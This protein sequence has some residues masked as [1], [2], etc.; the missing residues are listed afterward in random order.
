VITQ[1]TFA[2]V[3]QILEKVN[4]IIDKFSGR[5][6]SVQI[7]YD[8]SGE[9]MVHSQFDNSITTISGTDVIIFSY[10]TVSPGSYGISVSS[11]GR[12]GSRIN[13]LTLLVKSMAPEDVLPITTDC[14]TNVG[15]RDV[16]LTGNN[17]DKLVI[18]GRAMQGLSPVLAAN[19]T[20]SITSDGQP[21]SLVSLKD[22]GVSPDSVRNDGIYSAYF[23][24]FQPNQGESR[25]S[26]VCSVEGT[27][28]TRV[29]SQQIRVKRQTTDSSPSTPVCC[30]SSGVTEDTP[31]SP[32]GTFTR[33]R[34]GGVI[35]LGRT[36]PDTNIFPPGSIRD[37]RVGDFDEDHF[38]LSFTS[39]GSDLNTGNISDFIIFYSKNKNELNSL[40]ISSS[41]ARVTMADLDCT[42]C[43]MDPLPPFSKVK[44]TLNL[45]SF[46]P[47]EQVFFRVL[48]IDEGKK[49]SLS[50]RANIILARPT[51]DSES[52][53][54]H[55]SKISVIFLLLCV[56][57]SNSF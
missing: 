5:S 35:S 57:L 39:P 9:M 54:I 48:A 12:T 37:L 45:N 24:D 27:D 18:F 42:D 4:I 1:R 7:D 3:D 51:M 46:I 38:S 50:N 15:A 31:V 17:P 34:S 23:N 36:G 8:V 56:M 28:Q 41:V 20:A 21:D 32:T 14:W 19:L 30:G 43:T 10:Q 49:T 29:V 33:S 47:G 6:V 11:D 16:V 55:P 25:R 40:N 2:N 22:D 44:L 53:M 52:I 13:F 26:L